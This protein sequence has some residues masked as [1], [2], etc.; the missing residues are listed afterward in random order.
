[1]IAKGCSNT[2]K[3]QIWENYMVM[4]FFDLYTIPNSPTFFII[5]NEKNCDKNLSITSIILM[6]VQESC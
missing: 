3:Q 4:G 6:Q 2:N 5:M 1:M